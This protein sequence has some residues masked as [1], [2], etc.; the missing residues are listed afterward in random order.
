VLTLHQAQ[1]IATAAAVEA[2]LLG[3]PVAVAVVD[4]Y[5]AVVLAIRLDGAK[6][7]SLTCARSKAEI[8]AMAAEEREYLTHPE[9]LGL[10]DGGVPVYVLGRLAGAVGVCGALPE[11]NERVAR[12]GLAALA[13]S[14]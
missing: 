7:S 3:M 1:A 9:W 6:N 2:E 4:H 12:A 5:R 10:L 13:T 11:V 14:S 8:A